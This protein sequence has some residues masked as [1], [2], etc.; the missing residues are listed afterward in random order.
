MATAASKPNKFGAA[1]IKRSGPTPTPGS[2][3]ERQRKYTLLLNS[4]VASDFDE[5]ALALSRQAGRK[6]DKSEIVRALVDL[7]HTDPS[8]MTQVSQ[9]LSD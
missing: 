4:S 6:V 8:V 5:D 7:L 9:R 2:V 1:A 3:G